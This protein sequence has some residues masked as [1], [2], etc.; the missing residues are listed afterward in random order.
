MV[1]LAVALVV[2][3]AVAACG[4]E[5]RTDAVRIEPV[6]GDLAV[7]TVTAVARERP[8]PGGDR[9]SDQTDTRR[10]VFL[11]AG[12]GGRD[13]GWGSYN[14]LPAPPYEKDLALEMAF[15]VQRLLEAEGYR[16]V[17]SRTADAD[18]N[19][20]E[21]DINGDG[22]KDIVDELQ[23]RAD[24][25][26]ASGA[27]VMLSLH[28]NGLGGSALNGAAA[29]YNNAREFSDRN[30]H[31]AQLV[32][33]AQLEAFAS[34]GYT[35]RDWGALADDTFATPKQSKLETSYEY[36]TLIG[37]TGPSRTR[38]SM[39]PAAIAEPLYLTNPAERSLALR[40][41]VKDALARGYTKAIREFLAAGATPTTAPRPGAAVP[42]QSGTAALA[43]DRVQTRERVVALTF[44]AGAETGLAPQILDT[45]TRLDV[46]ASFGLTGRWCEQ[47]A[48]LCRRVTAEGHTVINH[49]LSH[50]SWTGVSPGTKPLSVEQRRDEVRGA[51]RL[52]EQTAGTS[53]RPYFRSP[54]GDRDDS[55]QRDLG[56]LG[57]RYNLLWSFDSGAWR[58]AKAEAIIRN[59][60][61]AAAPGAIYVFHVAEREDALA[62]ERLIEGIRAAGFGFATVAQLLAAQ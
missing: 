61:L 25:A 53:G 8:G 46:R 52:L 22:V 15:R 14:F 41:D 16:V 32:Q 19:E 45:L 50:T 36:N 27:A 1:R 21:K 30:K 35:S 29:F 54:Y 5:A 49:T 7:A 60:V 34:V 56:A 37:P 47:N 44:D 23:A 6:G 24:L 58:G 11:D 3:L 57:Y 31:F 20:P 38:P 2:A 12:H 18:A 4:G 43:V 59:G 9:A 28:Y 33:A 42:P 48:A 26:N 55:V 39:M 51:E 10:T 62:L 17:L 40:D 13:P